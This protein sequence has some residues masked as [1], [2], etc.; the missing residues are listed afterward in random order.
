MIDDVCWW[1]KL[2]NLGF[3]HRKTDRWMNE[4]DNPVCQD[5]PVCPDTPV[6]QGTQVCQDTLICQI[7]Y[8]NLL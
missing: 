4:Q 3:G 1:E 6:A 7:Q 2:I 8:V 5:T